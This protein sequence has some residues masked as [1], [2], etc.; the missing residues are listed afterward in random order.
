[1]RMIALV[2]TR[3]LVYGTRALGAG[4]RFDASPIDAA[5]LTYR[6]H[7]AF[8]PRG[9]VQPAPAPSIESESAPVRRV[10]VTTI[11]EADETGSLETP[12]EKPARRRYQ[13]RDLQAEE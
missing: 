5:V 6:R 12:I 2:A 9:M 4:E 10:R 3:P 1:M 13:R 11:D 8:A 7:A